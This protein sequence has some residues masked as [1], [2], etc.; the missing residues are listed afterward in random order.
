M[1]I[2]LNSLVVCLF[3][4]VSL[5]AVGQIGV[6][7]ECDNAKYMVGEAVMAKVTVDNDV[8]VPLVFD[9]SYHNA[10]LEVCASRDRASA[11]IPIIGS[12]DREIVIM[13]N[14]SAIELVDMNALVGFKFPGSYQVKARVRYDGLLFT[15]KSKGIDIVRGVEV[16]SRKQSL[17]GY[18]AERLVYSLRYI[19]RNKS[20]C[21]FLVVG[22][23]S[24]TKS[25]GTI[26]LGP[27]VRVMRP[28][29]KFDEDDRVVIVHQSGRKRFT[30]SVITVRHDG[31]EFVEQTHHK[32][33]GSPFRN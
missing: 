33:N 31:A 13:P 23:E 6:V 2:R 28:T 21:A 22:N 11:R 17:S 26:R 9:K 16:I 1:I 20:E 27:I 24:G 32:E 8:E 30:R 4:L 29:V 7:I 19:G 10:E 5:S 18:P 3:M 14:E 25:Y 12:V 15:S